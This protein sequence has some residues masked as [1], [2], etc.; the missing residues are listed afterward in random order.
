[1]DLP[2]YA[3]LALMTALPVA[4][5]PPTVTSEWTESVLVG[6][7]VVHR[8]SQTH[9]NVGI[10]GRGAVFVE[11]GR[12]RRSQ[13]PSTLGFAP[14]TPAVSRRDAARIAQAYG[15]PHIGPDDAQ[16]VYL[17]VGPFARLVW[18]FHQPF[19]PTFGPTA[20]LVMVDA[21]TA[22]PV[23][24]VETLRFEAGASVIDINPVTTPTPS[25][26]TLPDLG[27]NPTELTGTYVKA[28]NCIDRQATSNAF[29]T[30]PI[31]VCGAEQIATANASFDF[32]YTY[33]ND[34]DPE[35]AYAEVAVYHHLSKAFAYFRGLGMPD[36]GVKPLPALV[37]TRIAQGLVGDFD[38][39][40]A[41]NPQLPLAPFDNAF[42]APDDPVL[43]ALFGVQGTALYFGQGTST[44]FAYDGDVVYH[45]LGHA[46]I[47]RTIGLVPWWVADEQGVLPAPLAMHEALA[48]YFSSAI[49]GDGRVGEYAGRN[50]GDGAIRDLDRM[51]VC[52]SNLTGEAHDDS[53]FFSGALW[54]TRQ[55]LPAPDRARFDRAIAATL[56]R[57]PS[58]DIGYAGL[59]QAF[60]ASARRD[61]DSGTADALLAAFTARGVLGCRRVFEFTG[62]PIISPAAVFEHA[63][64]APGRGV[65]PLPADAPFAPGMIQFHVA[66]PADTT[67]IQVSWTDFKD[68]P[69]RWETPA[70]Y[71]PVALIR[72]ASD[73]IAFGYN[74]AL[75]H[76]AQDQLRM[77]E[78]NSRYS[79]KLAV[80]R[81]AADAYVMVVNRGFEN[82]LYRDV[83]F[84]FNIPIN[85]G[86]GTGP[87]APKECSS[88][89]PGQDSGCTCVAPR[90][91]RRPWL[92]MVML[93]GVSIAFRRRHRRGA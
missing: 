40:K 59:A 45:E 88:L 82:G 22:Q 9:D 24:R 43:A 68:T 93:L 2:S 66:L 11:G 78:L 18:A 35:D 70:S 44:D 56:I 41:R 62:T 87:A 91:D 61:I 33:S 38:D 6:A 7:E 74:G 14:S 28:L 80:P 5:T 75:T 86:V 71:D 30:L 85:A 4:T 79:G 23:L 34:T 72:F 37:N 63:F 81:G 20:P 1:M 69:K 3:A 27:P 47:D 16:L 92:A 26:V 46:M 12:S 15:A 89:C 51:D 48:D 36:L 67:T 31:H 58:G 29:G 60:V 21:H 55:A 17:P 13:P 52:P 39:D 19:D 64:L 54:A 42:Y 53:V 84:L 49:A 77:V 10:L 83:N 25:Q 8:F 32:P 50:F 73:P 57:A 65:V 90:A 76:N